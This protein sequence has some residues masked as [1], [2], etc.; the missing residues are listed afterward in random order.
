MLSTESKPIMQ[1]SRDLPSS[2]LTSAA[3]RRNFLLRGLRDRQL[4]KSKFSRSPKTP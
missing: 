3:A 4:S 1:R 2:V